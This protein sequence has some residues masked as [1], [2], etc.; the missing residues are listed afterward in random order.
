MPDT[1]LSTLVSACTEKDALHAGQ[2]AAMG[3]TASVSSSPKKN[4][5]KPELLVNMLIIIYF[6]QNKLKWYFAVY[7]EIG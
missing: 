7:R 5:F 1:L 6:L 2:A 4:L 3:N